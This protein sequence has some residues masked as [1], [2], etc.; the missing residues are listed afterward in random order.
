MMALLII[1]TC[2]QY[3]KF[4]DNDILTVSLDKASVFPMTRLADVK[5]LEHQATAAGYRD[6]IIKK[7]I[8]TEEDVS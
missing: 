6:V 3:L 4:K 2:N 7:L 5:A 1:K 8:L